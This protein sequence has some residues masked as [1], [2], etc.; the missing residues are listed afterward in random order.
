MKDWGRD[1]LRPML[2]RNQKSIT[3]CVQ[4]TTSNLAIFDK[5]YRF[6]LNFAEILCFSATSGKLC[7]H[8]DLVIK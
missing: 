7:S 5:F 6:W 1:I 3:E 8:G 4:G 2:Y